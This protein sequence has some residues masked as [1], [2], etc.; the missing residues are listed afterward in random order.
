MLVGPTP[1]KG[2]KFLQSPWWVELL[3]LEPCLDKLSRALGGLSYQ[4]WSLGCINALVPFIRCG[5]S[6]L[7]QS[8]GWN[9]R[10]GALEGLGRDQSGD[11]LVMS[12]REVESLFDGLRWFGLQKPWMVLID[13][14]YEIPYSCLEYGIGMT[15][16]KEIWLNHVYCQVVHGSPTTSWPLHH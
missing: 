1:S 10:S 11:G 6:Y 4:S 3:F 15:D 8:L 5:L 7:S 9:K 14:F 2:G 16:G 12:D 13:V